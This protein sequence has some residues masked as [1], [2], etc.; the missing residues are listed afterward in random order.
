MSSFYGPSCAVNCKSLNG[1]LYSTC[2]CRAPPTDLCGAPG[3]SLPIGPGGG[4][5][6]PARA[7]APSGAP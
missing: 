2:S 3:S 7:G 4:T 6:L 1:Q 5:A